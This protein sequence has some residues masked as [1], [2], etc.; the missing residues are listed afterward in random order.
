MLLLAYVVAGLREAGEPSRK[1]MIVDLAGESSRGSEVGLYYSIRGFVVMPG[2]LIGAALW[3]SSPILPFLV[4]SS[5]AWAGLVIFLIR[6][7]SN[8]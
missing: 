4:G 7:K 1:A 2:S 5:I 8:P 3:S 6:L